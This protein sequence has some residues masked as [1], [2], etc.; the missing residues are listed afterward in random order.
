LQAKQKAGQRRKERRNKQY[1][2]Q[3]IRVEAKKGKRE[4]E[5]REKENTL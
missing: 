3:G 1:I 2:E 4:R 5:K